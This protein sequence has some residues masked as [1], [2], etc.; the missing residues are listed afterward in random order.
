[1]D[2]LET[3]FPNISRMPIDISFL[4]DPGLKKLVNLIKFSIPV[5]TYQ[6]DL[7]TLYDR[8]SEVYYDYLFRNS[9]PAKETATKPHVS[10]LL[11]NEVEKKSTQNESA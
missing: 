2:I 1:M 7:L 5:H 8:I 4:N 11:N 9:L 6:S 10:L 3:A